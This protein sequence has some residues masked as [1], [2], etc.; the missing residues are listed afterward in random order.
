MTVADFVKDFLTRHP[1]CKK[2]EFNMDA[3][4]L[5]DFLLQ[6]AI[7]FKMLDACAAGKPPLLGCVKEVE[8]FHDACPLTNFPFT[9]DFVKAS[10]GRM[11]DTIV[12]QFGYVSTKKQLNFSEK[13][14]GKY[15]KSATIF[16]K[17][18]PAK[19]KVEKKIV[20]A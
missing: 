6:H 14:R 5:F 20:E 16:S 15:F 8:E 13:A 1:I 17:T 12:A 7:I 3:R 10:V 4:R 9:D 18:G 11:V 19:Y 2:F